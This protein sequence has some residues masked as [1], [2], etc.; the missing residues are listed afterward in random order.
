MKA[1][2]VSYEELVN[3]GNFS[4]RKISLTLKLEDGDN[5]QTVFDKAR[6]FVKKAHRDSL[7][8]TIPEI[9]RE[10]KEKLERQIVELQSKISA[11]VYYDDEIPF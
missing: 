5:A 7:N 10:E 1:E 2:T 4:H 3:T 6:L 9:T 8:Y 11:P